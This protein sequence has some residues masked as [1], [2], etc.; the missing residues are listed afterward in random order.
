MKALITNLYG[1]SYASVAQI[2]QQVSASYA[3]DLGFDEL[4]IY[5][6]NYPNEPQDSLSSRFDGILAKLGYGDVVV[7][8]SPSWN[9]LEW[10]EQFMQ[11]VNIYQ[12]VKKVMFIHDFVPLMFEG[13]RYLFDRYINFYN[14]ADLVIVASEKLLKVLRDHGL[15]VKRTVIQHMWDHPCSID[16]TVTPE[17][18]PLIQFA[19]DV[20]KFD[21]VKQ[22]SHDDVKLQLF[23]SKQDWGKDRN[24]NFVGWQGDPRLLQTLRESGGFGLVWGE[25]PY[26]KEYMKLNA[27][28][29]LSTYLAAG[30]PI[31]VNSD[32]PEIDTIRR[33]NLGLVADSLDEA[34][35][36]VKATTADQ[37]TEM[38]QSV[39]KFADLIRQGYFTKRLLIEAVFKVLYE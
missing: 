25:E 18:K 2:A 38:Q 33:K 28:Y 23:E 7:F 10:D 20:N 35:A 11:R 31:I 29:K 30:I 5:F 4:S 15:T 24:I 9:S 6:Y 17:Y 36:K 37:Y 12:G 16:P 3:K 32:T 39:D 27:S 22:W 8:Q 1:M 34:V 13:N 19:G 14:Q 21:F 26:W